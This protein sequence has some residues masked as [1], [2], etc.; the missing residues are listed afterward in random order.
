MVAS[1]DTAP[2]CVEG[3]CKCD[4]E[5]D[6]CTGGEIC[7]GK[8]CVAAACGDAPAAC[9]ENEECD[10]D[11]CKCPDSNGVKGPSCAGNPGGEFCDTTAAAPTCKCTAD[12]D[13]CSGNLLAPNCDAAAGQC[14]CAPG[15][16]GCAA[17]S[18]TLC[19]D[20]KCMC[21]TIDACTDAKAPTC[22]FANSQCMCGTGPGCTDMT[23]ADKCD[24]ANNKCV[25]GETGDACDQ[26]SDKP[27]CKDGACAAKE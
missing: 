24:D 26:T 22:D 27:I 6:A 9:P 11:V 18:G 3:T 2:L 1:A 13:S 5:V 21:G 10:S 4:T 14:D 17:D 12:V 8:K 19:V 20:K 23:N 15:D 25:C 16:G 7:I